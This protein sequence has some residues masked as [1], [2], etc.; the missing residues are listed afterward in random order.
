MNNYYK[1]LGVQHDAEIIVIKAA[2]KALAQRYHPDKFEG[3]KDVANLRMSEINQAYAVLS[4]PTLKNAYDEQIRTHNTELDEEDQFYESDQSEIDEEW[5][6][7]IEYYPDLVDIEKKLSKLSPNLSNLF[8]VEIISGKNISSRFEIAS[9]L[10]DAFLSKYF[11]NDPAIK[12]F[13]KNLL[14]DRNKEAAK[15]LNEAIDLFGD[16]T[17][18]GLL[19]TKISGKF[20]LTD[21]N[22]DHERHK[23]QSAK[24]Y[25]C[26]KCSYYGAFLKT[27]NNNIGKFLTILFFGWIPSAVLAVILLFLAELIDIKF[28]LDAN[29]KKIIIIFFIAFGYYW[30][31][32]KFPIKRNSFKCP[33]CNYSKQLN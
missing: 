26:D 1:V 24:K 15:E 14:L 7:A 18:A 8:K 31:F 2:Y 11:G 25:R 16:K 9:S 22:K 23:N 20:N 10:E 6:K 3:S 27:T 19:I 5:E 13:A 21:E 30:F 12:E 29:V 33:I 32:I 17:D 28:L 4:D